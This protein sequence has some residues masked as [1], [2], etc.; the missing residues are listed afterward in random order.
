MRDRCKGF[1]SGLDD[2]LDKLPGLDGQALS[3]QILSS[4]GYTVEGWCL[5][6]LLKPTKDKGYVQVSW[7]GAN[8]F[9]V[10]GELL[11]WAQGITLVD[12]YQ[13]SHR[14][15][16]PLCLIAPHVCSESITLN[17]LRKGCLVWVDCP[18]YGL[19]ILVYTHKPCYIKFCPGFDSWED[20]L[21]RGMHL[22]S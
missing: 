5:L 6:S 14:C 13:A 18:H 21:E 9:C 12:K 2:S 4:L 15:C 1:A 19:K 10:L 20:F 16:Q 3:Q 17:N 7:G 8:K 22:P 11:L